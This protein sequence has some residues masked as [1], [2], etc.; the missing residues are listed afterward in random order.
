MNDKARFIDSMNQLARNDELFYAM[1]ASTQTT[2]RRF[3]GQVIKQSW[4]ALV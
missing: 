3:D 2:A 4:L 1:S